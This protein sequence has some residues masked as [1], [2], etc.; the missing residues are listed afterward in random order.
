MIE[1]L[2]RRF[3]L[4]NLREKSLKPQH[5]SLFSLSSYI[6]NKNEVGKNMNFTSIFLSLDIEKE[7]SFEDSG[8]ILRKYRTKLQ[9]QFLNKIAVQVEPDFNGLVILIIDNNL[10]R[11]K[12]R[13]EKITSFIDEQGE[14]RVN[15]VS[16]QIYSWFQGRFVE[17][18]ANSTNMGYDIP[19]ER[20]KIIVYDNEDNEPSFSLMGTRSLRKSLRIPV[21]K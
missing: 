19:T 4:E 14:A 21:R 12:N 16:T 11:L 9:Q 15:S 5:I 1:A 13:I 18:G 8:A 7:N 6:L 3:V 10:E 17:T 2:I 20:Q